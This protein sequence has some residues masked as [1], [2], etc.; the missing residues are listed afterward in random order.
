ML[1]K[2]ATYG[3]F[4]PDADGRQFPCR[5]RIAGDFAQMAAYGFNAVRTY[6]APPVDLLDEAVRH[7]LKV[8][9]GLPW[10]QHVA[11][12]DDRR[13]T[14]EIYKSLREHARARS[15]HPA[16]LLFSIGNE[17]PS[18]IVRWHGAARIERFLWE[19]Y[20][21]IKSASPDALL[22]Y[23]NY[24]P[25]DFL[26]LSFLDL[27]AF[28]VFLHREKDMLAYLNRLQIIAGQ[29]PL[30]LTELG[31]DSVR[32]GLDGQAEIVSMQ[33]RSAFAKGACGAVV[34]SWTDEWWRGGAV[35][36]DWAFGLVDAERRTVKPALGAVAH[37]FAEAPFPEPDRARWPS[38]TVAICAYNAAD[39]IGE[40]LSSMIALNYPALDI[41]VINDGSR[42]ATS[43]I[44]HQFR[45]VRVIDVPNG[46]L[47]AAR[48]LALQ[49]ATGEI[50]AYTDADVR[51][52][53]DWLTYLIQPFV[54]SNAAAVGGP[55][56]VPADD[57]WMAQ[58]VARAPGGPTHV[59]L[60]DHTAEHVPGCN[61][62][63]RRNV[64]L[65]LGGFN[66]VFVRA[67]DDVDIC[68]RLQRK[69][70]RIAFSPSALVWHRHRGSIRAYWKQ[71]VGYGEGETWLMDRHPEK[72]VGDRPIWRGR[73]Y[74]PIPFLRSLWPV[75]VHTGRWGSAA[76]PSVYKK[77]VHP[78]AYL[79]HRVRWQIF[80]L[81]LV[82]V[83]GLG[84]GMTYTAAGV[85]LAVAGIAGLATTVVRCLSFAS[86][87]DLDRL[88]PIGGCPRRLNRPL[89]T[90]VIGFLH[91]LQPLARAVG[92]L[93]AVTVPGGWAPRIR[94]RR[95]SPSSSS[96]ADIR[97]SLRLLFGLKDERRFWSESWL[98]A[99]MLLSKIA[100][101]MNGTFRPVEVDD[102][103]HA[104]RDIRAGVAGVG[105]LDV[106]VLIEEH[107]KGRCLARIGTRLRPAIMRG[108][109]PVG[110]TAL[111]AVALPLAH[112][113][114]MEVTLT[115]AAVFV[116]FA[117]ATW[118]VSRA[119]GALRQVVQ[120]VARDLNL[121][122]IGSDK[123]LTPLF[124][125]AHEALPHASPTSEPGFHLGGHEHQHEI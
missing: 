43:E 113:A 66:P 120:E 13:L 42:D 14:R 62:A 38:V 26:D 5:E 45:T 72:F 81:M 35:V 98:G 91:Y 73:I 3:T 119:A 122:S 65:D 52:D 48:N 115:I 64:L 112:P 24:P 16:T 111:V 32:E 77:A 89:Y 70:Y 7:G 11:F 92:R 96:S 117:F 74:S 59:L 37:I 108:L 61:M 101:R 67:G 80:S 21:E 104:D 54:N 9:I 114:A 97:E 93:R 17:I 8:M 103:W 100:D 20:E 6:T 28:N 118:R 56:V 10:L 51:A 34:F 19:L 49:H 23:V 2:G 94:T 71:Q 102:G 63:F 95:P 1:V 4:A 88:P 57:P 44:A 85:L 75:H 39:T 125:Q 76:F 121:Y 84:L 60:S 105:A 124:A 83:G 40:C 78:L 31:A 110:V 87:S 106:R 46:G 41:L 107:A 90:F 15:D 99:D 53:P 29:R 86:R 22:T 30:L 27:C 47:S 58:C 116:V 79:P 33:V 82:I 50:I 18:A 36:D 12:L 69:G 25:T 123:R 68:W 55:N 109:A